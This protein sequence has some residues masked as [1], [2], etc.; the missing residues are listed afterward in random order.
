MK[1]VLKTSSITVD[2]NKLTCGK[3]IL[4]VN[5]G[6]EAEKCALF[7]KRTKR[8]GSGMWGAQYERLPECIAATKQK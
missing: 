7:G 2:C 3:C 4:Q 6:W 1:T 8:I 5:V